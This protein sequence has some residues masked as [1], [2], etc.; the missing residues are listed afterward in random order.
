[1]K[2]KDKVPKFKT[3]DEV[4]EFWDTH[5]FTDYLGAAQKVEIKFVDTRPKKQ[6]ISLKIDPNLK[7]KVQMLAQKRGTRYQTLINMWIKEK[8]DEESTR[9]FGHP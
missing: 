5:D 3:E 8:A 4:R 7:S 6:A 9:L 2:K 1:M